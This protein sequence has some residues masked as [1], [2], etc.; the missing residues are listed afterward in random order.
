MKRTFTLGDCHGGY[1]ALLE[2]LEWSK[3]DY[4]NDTLIFLGDVCDGWSETP[5]CIEE[6]M[7]IKNLIWLMGNHD[8][9][10]IDWYYK[11]Y[12]AGVEGWLKHGGVATL[13]A[14]ERRRDLLEKHIQ[15]LEQGLPY[16]VDDKNRAFVHAGIPDHRKPLN[17]QVDYFWTRHFYQNATVWHQQN[18]MINTLVSDN[19]PAVTEWFLGHTPTIN[20]KHHDVH[21]PVKFSNINFVDT[22]AAFDG[23]LT[24]FNVD[25]GEYIQS[26][27]LRKL[28]Y[29]EKGRN[30]ISLKEEEQ[31]KTGNSL[32][33][34]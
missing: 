32:D 16:Y 17:Q 34:W 28:Y 9:W 7:K 31:K 27:P 26:N 24:I 12:P 2:V 30:K 25:T 33:L 6:L 4:E 5:E 8:Q 1:K 20:F 22:G 10:F 3:F 18:F 13:K 29:D 15:W 19:G 14:Y 23:F 11:R 21:L